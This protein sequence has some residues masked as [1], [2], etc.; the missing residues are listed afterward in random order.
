MWEVILSPD[1]ASTITKTI[2]EFETDLDHA[3]GRGAVERALLRRQ[4]KAFRQFAL[5]A[6]NLEARKIPPSKVLSFYDTGAGT[7]SS[8]LL[9][10]GQWCGLFSADSSTQKCTGIKVYDASET[11]PLGKRLKGRIQGLFRSHFQ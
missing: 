7:V 4:Y 2:R 11:P 5:V 1:F 10:S 6:L 9:I 8:Y 3:Q